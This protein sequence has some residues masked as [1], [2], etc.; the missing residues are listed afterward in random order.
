MKIYYVYILKCSDNS[1]YTG[2]TNNLE[3]RVNEHKEGNDKKAHT[4]NKRPIELVYFE[5][6]NEINYAI[7]WEKRIKGWTR[8]KKECLINDN[9][10]KLKELSICQNETHHKNYTPF[11]AFAFAK[12]A[13]GDTE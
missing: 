13:Q 3:K 10:E 12:R 1:Y 11:E 5:S 6:F 8:K 4:F 7:E 9:F 2:V